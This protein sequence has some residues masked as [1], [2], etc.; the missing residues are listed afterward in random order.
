[1]QSVG[2]TYPTRL[3]MRCCCSLLQ[4]CTCLPPPT[5]CDTP[6]G[7]IYSI[8]PAM[9]VLLVPIVGAMTTGEG[10]ARGVRG[11]LLLLLEWPRG[12]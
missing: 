1:M 11:C 5:R 2:G 3:R 7:L 4:R 6:I 10:S 12:G 9:I 8:N